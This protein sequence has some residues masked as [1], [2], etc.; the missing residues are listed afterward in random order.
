M[1]S[2]IT[3]D[4]KVRAHVA[5]RSRISRKGSLRMAKAMKDERYRNHGL[6]MVRRLSEVRLGSVGATALL[7]RVRAKLPSNGWGDG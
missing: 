4:N 5:G 2:S 6:P 3:G 7:A 1:N